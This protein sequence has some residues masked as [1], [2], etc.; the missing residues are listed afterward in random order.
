MAKSNLGNSNVTNARHVHLDKAL[1]ET[2]TV[3]LSRLKMVDK[4]PQ[5]QVVRAISGSTKI[6]TSVKI[7]QL[8]S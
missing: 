8:F 5:N 3:V 1:T 6:Q 2:L 7:A 4:D